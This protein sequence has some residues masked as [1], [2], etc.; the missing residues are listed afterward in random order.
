MAADAMVV[1]QEEERRVVLS[2]LSEESLG[3]V[4]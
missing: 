4:T 1:H 3:A 2:E